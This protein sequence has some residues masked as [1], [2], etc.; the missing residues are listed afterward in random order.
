[1]CFNTSFATVTQ[2]DPRINKAIG[3]ALPATNHTLPI[4]VLDLQKK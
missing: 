4:E 1:M 3:L 2:V